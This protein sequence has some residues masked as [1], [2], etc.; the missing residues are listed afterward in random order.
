MKIFIAGGTGFI[1]GNLIRALKEKGHNIRCLV[2]TQERASVCRKAGFDAVVGDI[3]DRESLKGVLDGV[4]M[5]V[6]LVGIIEESGKATFEGVHVEGTRNLLDEAIAANVAHFFYQSA[7]GASLTSPAGY[8][9]TKA[10]AEELVKSSGLTFTIFRPSLVIGDNDGFTTRI[11]EL[12]NLAPVVV[13]PG[14][15][16][17]RFQPLYVGDWVKCFMTVI[18]DASRITHHASRIYELGGPEHLTYNEMLALIMEAMNVKKPVMHMPLTVAKA[19]MPFM[20]IAK[21]LGNLLGMKV[22]SITTEQL[23]LLEIDNICDTDS[24]VR[25]FGFQPVAFREAL[26]KFLG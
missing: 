9:K 12:I 13:V 14:E 22:P 7:L 1:G 16:N 24:V 2:R 23:S 25:Q 10:E 11:R 15:G 20:G 18:H 5:V 26:S 6:H 3:T 19:G 21:G 17:A 4:E 8:Q